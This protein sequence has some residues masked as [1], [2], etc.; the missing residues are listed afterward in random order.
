MPLKLILAGGH[1]P[2]T[3][4]AGTLSIGR[5]EGNDWVLPDPD[6][7]LSKTHCVLSIEDGR[8]ILTDVSTNGVTI[9]GAR[10][11]T[12]RDSRVV[13]TDGDTFKLG[14]YSFTA[15]ETAAAAALPDRNPDRGPGR[16]SLANADSDPLDIDP[17]D[18]PL[19]APLPGANAAFSHPVRHVAPSRRMDDPFDRE[20]DARHRRPDTDDDL[21]QGIKPAVDWSGPAQPDHADAPRPAMQLP[22]VQ[23]PVARG[24]IDFD[25]LIGDLSDLAPGRA[26]TPVRQAVSPAPNPFDA[27]DAFIDDPIAPPPAA[28]APA[29]QPAAPIPQMAAPPVAIPQPAPQ[30]AQKPAPPPP[31]SSRAAPAD[32]LQAAFLAFLEGAG[33]A[34]MPPPPDAEAA[35]RALG[36]LF[37]VMTEGLREV[38][39]SRATVKNELRVEQT[40]IRSTN[41][42]PLKFSLTAEDALVALLSPGRPG[43]MPPLAAAR[44]AFDDIRMHELAVMAGVQSALVDLLR[45]F[46]PAALEARSVQGKLD[47]LLP[48]ARKARL[49][50]SFQDTYKTI[51]AEAEDDFQSV[52]W[53]LLRQ[54]LHGT[55]PQG[56]DPARPAAPA[57]SFFRHR[58]GASSRDQ[59][60]LTGSMVL[61]GQSKKSGK[62]GDASPRSHAGRAPRRLTAVA[63]VLGLAACGA[64]PPPPPPTIVALELTASPDVNPDPVRPGR[65]GRGPRL[66]ARRRRRVR[67]GG[68]LPPAE[69]RRRHARPRPR[70]ERRVSPRPRHH[71]EGEADPAR[72]RPRAGHLRRLSRV[73]DRHLAHR[74]PR[75]AA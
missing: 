32:P 49:W 4:V 14:S 41:N 20:D 40:M 24:A 51:A 64:P 63:L 5:G 54:G 57:I 55:D 70:Q 61:T 74:R 8:W 28:P 44:E 67:E 65:A 69:R 50:E 15:E 10:Q 3:L 58:F 37:R 7:H 38:L 12:T 66:P 33:T 45:R 23:T 43:Y 48:A 47:A 52:F 73:P 30:P 22:R 25:A 19:G 75:P 36:A 6:R 60:E 34:A 17:L 31:A 16:A 35:L 46:D 71:E 39:M 9:N 21:F 1:P 59:G 18:D 11:P 27:F 42:N 68:V 13:L 72:H 2:R 26:V 29:P 53:P 56:I 62:P